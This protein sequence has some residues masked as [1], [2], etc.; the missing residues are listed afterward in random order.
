M[1]RGISHFLS[2]PKFKE[3]LVMPFRRASSPNQAEIRPLAEGW[4]K[5]VT[6]RAFGEEGPGLDLDF[7]TLEQVAVDAAQALIQGTI[8]QALRQ[9][10]VQLGA[11]QPCPTCERAC[12][13]E[14]VPR[15]IVVRAATVVYDEP[16]C[17]CPSCRRDFFPSPSRAPAGR[18]SL[19][20]VAP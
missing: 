11:E 1:S 8:E 18:P 5:V 16:K 3:E 12:P 6:R 14:T 4:G 7:D 10:L 17:H 9:Q 20:P 19:P 13:V 2:F 15:E